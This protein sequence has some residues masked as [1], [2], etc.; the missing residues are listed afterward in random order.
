MAVY[1]AECCDGVARTNLCCFC[2]VGGR[3]TGA[4]DWQRGRNNYYGQPEERFGYVCPPINF[5]GDVLGAHASG[6]VA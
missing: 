1:T 2:N 4:A 3:K 6:T 5:F